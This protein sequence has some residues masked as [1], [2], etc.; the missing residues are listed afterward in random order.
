[1]LGTDAAHVYG[2]FL[3]TL[4][5]WC[6]QRAIAYQGVPVGTIKRFIT[7]KGNADKAGGDR[8][9]S[10]A[11]LP[12]RRRQRGRRH[13][14]PALGDRDARGR[15]MTRERLPHRRAAETVELEHNGSR[16]TVTIGF[17]PDG[18][19]GEVFTHGIRSG[20]NL[21]ALLADACVVVSCL[22]QHGVEP[23][24]IAGSMG[25]L[26]NAEPASIIGAVI[27]LAAAM[28]PAAR[29]TEEART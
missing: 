23:R 26:G 7:G 8:R 22:M 27:D 25:R 11:W 28:G 4:T 15:A 1:M 10:C 29:A 18:R 19:P 6:E 20:S 9:R 14:H 13:R 24:E 17:Y 16:F 5:S 12:S 2:G 21:D 3:A